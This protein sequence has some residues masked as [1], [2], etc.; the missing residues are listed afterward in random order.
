MP[1]DEYHEAGGFGGGAF[2]EEAIVTAPHPQ[3]NTALRAVYALHGVLAQWMSQPIDESYNFPTTTWQVTA[4]EVQ[5]Y[6]QLDERYAAAMW[7]VMDFSDLPGGAFIFLDPTAAQV[8]TGLSEDDLTTD[9]G[10]SYVEAF[11]ELFAHQFST[12]WAE[13]EVASF[14]AST[15]PSPVAPSLM[16]LQP[17]FPG[18]NNKTP[19][20]TTAFRVSQP[21]GAVTAR[22]VLGIPQAYLHPF[23]GGLQAI[24]EQTYASQDPSYFHERLGYLADVPV[25][26]TVMLGKAEM[27]VGEL[28][29]LEEGDVLP[30][31]TTVGQPLEVRL[32]KTVLMGK[33]GTSVDGRH[34]A[35]QLV[36]HG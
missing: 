28:Q 20:I 26:V 7:G 11:I 34:L 29:N 6:K 27:T 10:Q 2:S 16:D 25:P 15:F 32:G 4:V 3:D 19:I 22:V 33:P 36:V 35:V 13:H 23:E 30:L 17:M 18:L 24:G 9:E 12:C 21:G 8:V 31:N 5:T 1:Y 14:N